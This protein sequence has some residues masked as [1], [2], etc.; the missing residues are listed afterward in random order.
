[1]IYVLLDSRVR[2]THDLSSLETAMYGATPMSPAR[3]TEGIS[4]LGNIFTQ[5]YGQ[6]EVPMAINV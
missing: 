4:E 6:S 1:M 5:L 3:L 2:G